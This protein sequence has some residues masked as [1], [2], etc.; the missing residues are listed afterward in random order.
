MKKIV[1]FI[2]IFLLV[3]ISLKIINKPKVEDKP[4]I[5]TT[6]CFNYKIDNK[7][8]DI[9]EDINKEYKLVVKNNCKNDY[10]YI[11]ILSV[12]KDYK[13]SSL[14]NVTMNEVLRNVTY[15]DKNTQYSVSPG[16]LDSYI[17]KDDIIKPGKTL[18]YNL[19]FGLNESKD[20]VGWIAEI[21]VIGI[22]K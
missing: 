3:V 19:K 21:K 9:K 20:N 13:D 5:V 18:K 11:I 4:N 22:S 2:L 6:G 1:V 8:V 14:I 15:Y 7:D 12:D 17:L 16:Y 10:R